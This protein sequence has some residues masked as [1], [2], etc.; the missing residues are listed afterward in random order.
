VAAATAGLASPL[1]SRP[2]QPATLIGDGAA[3]APPIAR[4][5]AVADPLA[6]TFASA[7]HR[8]AG[9]GLFL[10]VRPLARL[11]LP[12]WLDRHPNHAADGFAWGLLRAIAHR[13]RIPEDDAL[14][15][16]IGAAVEAPDGAWKGGAAGAARGGDDARGPLVGPGEHGA[17][18]KKYA[19]VR[20]PH[21]SSPDLTQPS[22]PAN[23]CIDGWVKPS[24]DGENFLAPALDVWRVGLN[25]WLRRRAG[26]SLAET[27]RRPGWL[28]AD[29]AH[30][31]ARFPLRAA[32]IRLR[33]LALDV[34]PCWVPWLGRGIVYLYGDTPADR[35]AR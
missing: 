16:V 22:T 28:L 4:R 26:I 13:M 6:A 1:V 2:V 27:V 9:A 32:D 24:H 15:S 5:A 14:W 29:P 33:R 34:D 31:T 18:I 20:S 30:V 7:E 8:S 17:A 23:A 10:L 3:G 11:G 21:P 19:P 25:R 12:A 35:G